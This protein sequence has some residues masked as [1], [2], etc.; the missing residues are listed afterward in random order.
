LIESSTIDV[1]VNN[2]VVHLDGSIDSY[3]AKAEAESIAYRARGATQVRNHLSVAYPETLVYDPYVYDWSIDDYPWYGIV[4][5]TGKSDLEIM[6]DIETGLFWSPF[7]D[8]NNINVSV[9]SGIAT[10]TGSVG[11]LQEYNAVRQNAFE[12]GATAV[13]SKLNVR[14]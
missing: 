3:F 14:L 8:S 9:E 11:S 5:V 13:I 10:L 2:G 4:T 7:V 12:G 1:R 6:Q